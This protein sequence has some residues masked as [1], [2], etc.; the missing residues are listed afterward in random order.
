[1]LAALPPCSIKSSSVFGE[2]MVR[3]NTN[4][5]D[6]DAFALERGRGLGCKG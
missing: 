1:M 4:R 3:I 2:A 5:V 6:G